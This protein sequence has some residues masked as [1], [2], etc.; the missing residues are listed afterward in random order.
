MS[1]YLILAGISIIA[2]VGFFIW[3]SQTS[4]QISEIPTKTSQESKT[5]ESTAIQF[6]NPKKSAHYETN[7]P[8]HGTTLAG[9]PIDVVIDF[10]FDLAKPSE[11]KILKDNKDYGVGETIIDDNKLTMR[12]NMDP[13]SPDGKYQVTY[14]ACWPDTSCHDGSFEFVINRELANNFTDQTQRSEVTIN[15]SNSQF[16]PRDLKIKKGTKITW[17]NDDSVDHYINTDSHPAHT[18]FLDQN[19]RALKKG[20]SY[21]VTFDIAGIYPYHCSAHEATMKGNILVEN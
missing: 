11:I 18:Y 1:K 12:R 7:T 15:L 21:S 9:V 10:N 8:A 16:E 5:P 2:V 20:D 4:T 17:V 19:S 6:A 3:Q 13:A 14:N